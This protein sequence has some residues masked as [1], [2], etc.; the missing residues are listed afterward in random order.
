MPTDQRRAM[1]K[2]VKSC[3]PAREIGGAPG[4]APPN[5]DEAADTEIGSEDHRHSGIERNRGGSAR[6]SA[7]ASNAFCVM[8][9]EPWSVSA[10]SRS[11]ATSD[12]DD[13]GAD[14]A[15]SNC[16]SP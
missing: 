16:T 10:R 14:D 9:D 12:T 6:C 13:G 7:M 11:S 1:Q 3:C 4:W 5:R 2:W 8:G 15:N